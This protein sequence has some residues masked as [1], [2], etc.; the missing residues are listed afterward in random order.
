MKKFILKVDAET[1]GKGGAMTMLRRIAEAINR[2]FMKGEGW[3]ISEDAVDVERS[4]IETRG[5]ETQAL[6]RMT[7]E[8]HTTVVGMVKELGDLVESEELTDDEIRHA[9]GE[10]LPALYETLKEAGFKPA[11]DIHGGAG[12][13]GNDEK[14]EDGGKVENKE[15]SQ[16]DAPQQATE[17]AGGGR[18]WFGKRK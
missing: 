5:E 2:G 17:E 14:E 8:M 18:S 10:L 11:E 15:N 13:S 16:P 9:Q 1:D 12:G 7:E 4:A 3:A 6:D